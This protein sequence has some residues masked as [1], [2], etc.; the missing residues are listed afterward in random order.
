MRVALVINRHVILDR[1]FDGDDV[2][3]RANARPVAD[4]KD[5][6]VDGLG[7]MAPPHRQHHIGSLAPHTRQAFQR[8]AAVGHLTA[9]V[10]DQDAAQLDDVLGLVAV[11]ADGFDVFDHT[12]FAKRQH[13]LWRIGDGKKPFRG[14]VHTGISCLRGQRDRNDQRVGVHVIQFALGLCLDRVKTVK[15]GP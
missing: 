4:A 13:L 11:K 6:R 7:R 8:R 14:L 15:D 1:A 10:I 12:L 9:I 2:L 3:A 5:M